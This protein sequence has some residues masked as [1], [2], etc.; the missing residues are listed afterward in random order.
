[1]KSELLDELSRLPGVEVAPSQWTKEPAIWIRL[2]DER[3][4][5][6]VLELA[7]GAAAANPAGL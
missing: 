6:L 2:V 1:M 4:R 7:T 5:D 3:E